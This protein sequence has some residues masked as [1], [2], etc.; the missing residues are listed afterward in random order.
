M[1]STRQVAIGL[2]LFVLVFLG[3]VGFRSDT[4]PHPP[5]AEF[6]DAAISRYPDALAIHRSLRDDRT[7]PLWNN[8]LMGG[9]PFAANTGTK[10]WY[11]FTWLLV[12]VPPALH[13][14]MMIAFH[15]W[16]G[17]VGMWCWARQQSMI[18]D[19][20]LLAALGYVLAPKVIAHAGA[21]HTDLLIATGWL[22][23]ALFL[24]TDKT[25]T[26]KTII[27]LGFV[28]SMMFIGAIQMLHITFGLVAVA[29]LSNRRAF[30]F[31]KLGIL[32]G[33]F[34]GFAAVQ[35]MPLVNLQDSVARSD[36]QIEDAAFLSLEF[37]NLLSF[38]LAA[39]GGNHEQ[40]VYVG[41]P[42]L[43]LAILGLVAQPKKNRL[44]WGAILFSIIYALGDS[45]LVWPLLMELIPPLRLFRVPSRAW[46]IVALLM[47]YL[48]GWG[49]QA[50]LT[51][52]IKTAKARLI[53]IG[54]IGFGI[55]CN[56]ASFLFLQDTEVP[57]TALIGL[58]VLPITFIIVALVIF[59]QFTPQQA[60]LA[61]ML[62]AVIDLVWVDRTLIDGR[63]HWL[64]E[65]PPSIIADLADTGQRIYTPD[66]SIPQQDTAY[67]GIARFDG[68][69]P[70]VLERF[71]LPAQTATGVQQDGYTVSVPA[72][73]VLADDED[74]HIYKDAPMDARLLGQWGVEWV[75]VGYPIDIEG[76]TE[77]A[78]FGELY[79]YHNE[80]GWGDDITLTWDT[81]N[82]VTINNPTNRDILSV[83]NLPTWQLDTGDA[84]NDDNLA[85]PSLNGTYT[86]QDVWV[87]RGLAVTAITYLLA[88][89]ALGWMWRAQTS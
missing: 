80:F 26:Y 33:L 16:L 68:V 46:F 32:A 25:P 66:Y 18:R 10:L 54:L 44:W 83:V 37:G 36:I 40:M 5:D 23:W 24:S 89:I 57:T 82:Q 27:A 45:F 55:S 41:I 9:I 78:R 48:A 67:W 81:A 38:L 34:L 43:A 85:L 53:I 61:L 2:A 28:L 73:I 47:P 3:M 39:H 62:L 29:L 56:A 42:I 76:L 14:N 71:A 52:P 17:G 63:N 4:L 1:F 19:G 50:L 30:S 79:F 77:Q 69:D 31:Q 22:P 70:F 72:E 64:Q 8:H 7:I 20:A 21:G 6:S 59:E 15:L 60:I 65:T 58:M 49:V 87:W 13:I 35:W 84:I 51:T 86:Y 75:I 88:A 11:P 12:I 74:T